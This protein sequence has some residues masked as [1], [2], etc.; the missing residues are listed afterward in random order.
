MSNGNQGGAT[1][2]STQ[3]VQKD[4]AK[5][6]E[7]NKRLKEAQDG[8][9]EAKAEVSE[10]WKVYWPASERK[11]KLNQERKDLKAEIKELVSNSPALA[12]LVESVKA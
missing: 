10:I 3:N 9:Q 12:A 8:Y 2:P 11:K 1:A 6:T 5:L 7:L 4:L